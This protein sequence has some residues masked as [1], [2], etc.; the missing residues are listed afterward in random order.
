VSNASSGRLAVTSHK[1]GS[2]A[3]AQ[4]DNVAPGN[5]TPLSG[6][7]PLAQPVFY[8]GGDFLQYPNLQWLGGF[9]LLVAGSVGDQ[10]SVNYTT[11]LAT[12]YPLWSSLDFITN[13][14]GV[15]PFLDSQALT[16]QQRYYRRQ[17]VGP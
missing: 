3:T 4:F 7:W 6:T 10:F 5:L 16:N 17:Q 15:V 13:Q 12:P 14:Y 9:K 1:N 2:Y 11:N 8:T